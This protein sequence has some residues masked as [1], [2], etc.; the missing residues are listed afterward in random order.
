MFKSQIVFAP[1]PDRQ[2]RA[3]T[4]EDHQREKILGILDTLDLPRQQVILNLARHL[5]SDQDRLV[6]RLNPRKRKVER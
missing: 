5:K 3:E 6:R 4:T 2:K 1:L